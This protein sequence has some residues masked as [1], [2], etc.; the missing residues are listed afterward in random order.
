MTF[1]DVIDLSSQV[2]QR[3]KNSVL[4]LQTFLIKLLNLKFYII[5]IDL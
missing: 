3:I 2:L 5:V 1:V 4:L